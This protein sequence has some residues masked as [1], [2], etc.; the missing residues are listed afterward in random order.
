MERAGQTAG[1]HGKAEGVRRSGDPQGLE[2]VAG[3]PQSPIP[4]SQDT[5][6]LGS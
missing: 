5:N 1:V 4:P 2:G 3:G 6:H